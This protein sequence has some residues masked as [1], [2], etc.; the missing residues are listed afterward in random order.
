[1]STSGDHPE[2]TVDLGD[3]ITSVDSGGL[4]NGLDLHVG[5]L[6][7]THTDANLRPEQNRDESI[8]GP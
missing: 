6:V 5:H 7:H 2:A 4:S 1:M 3:D 8:V